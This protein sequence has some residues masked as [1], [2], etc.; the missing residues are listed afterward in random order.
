MFQLL[1]NEMDYL[2]VLRL[3]VPCPVLFSFA[4]Y[5]YCPQNVPGVEEMYGLQVWLYFLCL[6]LK[7][8]F[9]VNYDG[10]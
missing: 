4:Q 7:Q 3:P 6:F 10:K 2:D 1:S 5:L 8:L 9:T